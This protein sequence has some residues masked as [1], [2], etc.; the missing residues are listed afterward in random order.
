MEM[1]KETVLLS[2]VCVVVLALSVVSC[3]RR[4]SADELQSKIDSVRALENIEQLKLQGINLEDANPV[5]AYFDSLSVQPLPVICTEDYVTML[6]RF[7]EVPPVIASWL[8]ID[9]IDCKAKIL[10]ESLGAKLVLV[11]VDL[12]GDGDYFIWLYSLDQE[13]TPVDR[14]LLYAPRTVEDMANVRISD[15]S[16]TSDYEIRVREMTGARMQ[17]TVTIYT[18]GDGRTFIKR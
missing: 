7:T 1:K 18:V 13:C 11:A 5:V 16:I 10:P 4:M 8:Q 12:Q 14:V 3:G 15:F 17:Q 9:G 6:P 2:L